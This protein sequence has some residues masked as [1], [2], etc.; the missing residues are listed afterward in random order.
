MLYLDNQFKGYRFQHLTNCRTNAQLKRYVATLHA[1][2]RS[3]PQ[4]IVSISNGVYHPD[5]VVQL[6]EKFTV[7]KLPLIEENIELD[8]AVF[9]WLARTPEPQSP[10]TKERYY[11]CLRNLLLVKKNRKC[12]VKEWKDPS[13]LNKDELEKQEPL[14]TT[15]EIDLPLLLRTYRKKTTPSE[16]RQTR[17]AV[18]SYVRQNHG[19]HSTLWRQ[20]SSVPVI[21]YKPKRKVEHIKRDQAHEVAKA[22]I[23]DKVRLCFWALITTGLRPSEFFECKYEVL[24]NAVYVNHPD[25]KTES[26]QRFIPRVLADF[27]EKPP[28]TA[29]YFWK[30]MRELGYTTRDLRNSFIGWLQDCGIPPARQIYI[31]GHDPNSRTM[32]IYYQ[33]GDNDGYLISDATAIYNYLLAESIERTME[34][35]HGDKLIKPPEQQLSYLPKNWT[36]SEY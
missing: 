23:S 28:I 22:L 27:P 8:P 2:A 36:T 29:H 1:V 31:S 30:Q 6:A 3:Q 25:V 7:R 24:D 20:C 32:T 35:V 16:F 15:V 26:S 12:K 34:E 18:L 21:K 33:R 14:S 19:K 5:H 4:Y 9:L 17:A 11:R 13:K 10:L